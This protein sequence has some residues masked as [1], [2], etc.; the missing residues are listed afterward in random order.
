MA[1]RILITGMS[2]TG[3]S[4]VIGAMKA[5]GYRVLDMDEPGW[6]HRGADG[7]QLWREDRL[8]NLLASLDRDELFFLSGCAENQ[9]KFYPHFDEII[10]LSAPTEIII[11]RLKTRTTNS[12]GKDPAEL[13]EVIGYIETVEPLLRKGA[14]REI[15][16]SMPL[17]AVLKTILQLVDE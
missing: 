11:E 12:Y 1:K 9:G 16:T 15:D 17:D 10:L 5:R 6:T 14:S 2:G 8:E 7:G 13:D 3:K 4:T